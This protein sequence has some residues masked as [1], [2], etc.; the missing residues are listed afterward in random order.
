MM[1]QFSEI[2]TK[3]NTCLKYLNLSPIRLTNSTPNLNDLDNSGSQI[4][5]LPHRSRAYDSKRHL[6]SRCYNGNKEE[7]PYNNEEVFSMS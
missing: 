1:N 2:F 4:D 5:Q 7:Y 3:N 6:Q